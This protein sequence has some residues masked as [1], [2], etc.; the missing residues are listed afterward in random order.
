[1]QQNFPFFDVTENAERLCVGTGVAVERASTG[2]VACSD[3]ETIAEL[4]GEPLNPG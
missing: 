4:S 2:N 3:D 1:M